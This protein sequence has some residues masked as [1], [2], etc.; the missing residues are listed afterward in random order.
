MKTDKI[1]LAGVLGAAV[2]FLLGYLAYV[3]LLGEFFESNPGTVTGVMR[4]DGEMLWGPMIL[5]H[6]ALGMLFAFIYGRLG[7]INTLANGAKN[8]AVLGFLFSLAYD[9][10]TLGTTNILS[11]TAAAAD[12]VLT[13][14]I[15]AIMGGVIAWFLGR[16]SA[17]EN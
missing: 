10:I 9:M 16:G 12:I 4:G 17:T 6:L 3:M 13:T 5:G 14:V 1:L 15:F 8:G 2:A 11:K 7:K